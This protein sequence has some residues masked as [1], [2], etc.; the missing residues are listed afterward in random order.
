MAWAGDT[1]T[2]A[3]Q[4]HFDAGVAYVDDPS[5]PKWDDALKEFRAAYAESSSWK[6]L[7]NIGLSA[8]NLE[9]D[10]EAIEAFTEYL[11]RA[12]AAGAVV[13]QRKQMEKDIATLTASLVRINVEVEPPEAMLI[14]ERRNAK[15]VL[16]VNEYEIKNGKASLGLHPG[17]HK[18]TVQAPGCVTAEWS[19]NAG[20]DSTHTRQFKLKSQNET[21]PA[22]PAVAPE[23]PTVAVS[24]P[25]KATEHPSRTGMYIG[26]AATGVFSVAATVAGIMTLSKQSD[27]DDAKQRGDR[28]AAQSASDSGKTLA[29]VTD[30]SIGAAV[31][32]AG[33]TGYLILSSLPKRPEK[34]PSPTAVRFV[35]VIAPGN[36]GLGLS[37]T[38]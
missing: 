17:L 20:P 29:L 21:E 35:P 27:F 34:S 16:L 24:E 33:I 11:A 9:R 13:K 5:G 7:H 12:S 4:K 14:D 26:L 23:K 8:L 28:S 25:P 10:G 22:V 30:I 18:I 2:S 38:F 1:L 15:G 36:L 3:A 31:I 37:K 19:I 32:S 6:L